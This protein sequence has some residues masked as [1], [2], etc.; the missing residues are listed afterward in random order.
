MATK[1]VPV[2]KA[3]TAEQIK[4]MKQAEVELEE[5][6]DLDLAV[7]SDEEEEEEETPEPVKPKAKAV[8]V[9]SN[10]NK[11]EVDEY[12]FGTRTVASFLMHYLADGCCT[13]EELLKA[14]MSTEFHAWGRGQETKRTKTSLNVFLSDVRKPFATYHS[15]RSLI[16]EEDPETHKIKAEPK[17]LATIRK[18]VAGGILTEL[19]G[20][21]IRDHLS[22][23]KLI[24]KKYGVPVE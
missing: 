10:G 20:L 13:R 19:R 23:I 22:K 16:L 18:A 14:Y 5:E 1:K 17:R 2:K 3:P 7:P 24:R 21:N 15:S 4:K 8:P 9:A 12:G 11:A 6:L